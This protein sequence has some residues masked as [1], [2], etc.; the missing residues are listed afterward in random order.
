MQK[1][2]KYIKLCVFTQVS[3]AS[4]E[5]TTILKKEKLT[6]DNCAVYIYNSQAV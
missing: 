3:A 4:F 5:T 2:Q 6:L 1:R